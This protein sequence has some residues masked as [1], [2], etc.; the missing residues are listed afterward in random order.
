MLMRLIPF[1]A[2]GP[3]STFCA[4]TKLPGGTLPPSSRGQDVKMLSPYAAPSCVGVAQIFIIPDHRI[5][6]IAVE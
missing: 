6:L 5:E 3:P 2:P 1:A 4:P